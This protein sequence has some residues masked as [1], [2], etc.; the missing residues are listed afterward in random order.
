MIDEKNKAWRLYVR[1]N[2]ILFFFEKFTSLQIQLSDLIE[3]RKQ[4]YQF[5]LIEKL[6]DRK[7][8][9]KAYWSLLTTFLNKKKKPCIPPNFMKMI[10]LLT[11]RKMLTFLMNSLQKNV[12][13]FQILANFLVF[14]LQKLIIIYHL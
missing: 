8:S 3:T 14:L 11:F 2:K 10:S 13:L 9:P 7:T 5:R 6:R 1:I 12:Q 4:N